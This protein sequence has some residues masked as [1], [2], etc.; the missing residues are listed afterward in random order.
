MIVFLFFDAPKVFSFVF[1][2]II[3][4][5]LKQNFFKIF[6][7]MQSLIFCMHNEVLD[8]ITLDFCSVSLNRFYKTHKNSFPLVWH[9]NDCLNQ[10]LKIEK[11]N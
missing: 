11:S 9:F 6:F 8:T 3:K 5:V 10:C 2:R 1:N 4:F 7:C